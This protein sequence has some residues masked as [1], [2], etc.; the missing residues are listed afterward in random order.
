M[1]EYNTGCM[2]NTDFRYEEFE[3]LLGSFHLS[4]S[5]LKDSARPEDQ[6]DYQRAMKILNGF[7]QRYGVQSPEEATR[8]PRARESWGNAS[9]MSNFSTL[10]MMGSFWRDFV[11]G[12][13]PKTEDGQERYELGRLILGVYDR[14]GIASV[15]YEAIEG[16]Q[17]PVKLED[18]DRE[19]SS[20]TLAD[21]LSE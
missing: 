21:V 14:H 3:G 18:W 19:K 20:K 6:R 17:V 8:N 2:P 1:P 13:D 15:G 4:L 10:D 9:A 11:V 12:A 7:A 5:P 16:Q